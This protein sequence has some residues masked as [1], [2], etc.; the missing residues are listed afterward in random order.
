MKGLDHSDSDPYLEAELRAMLRRRAA[1]V[2]PNQPSWDDLLDRSTA[3]VVSLHT[4]RPLDPATEGRRHPRRERD[5]TSLRPAPAAAACLAVVMTAGVVI[6]RSTTPGSDGGGGSADQP[7]VDGPTAL[8]DESPLAAAGEADFSAAAAPPLL[9]DTPSRSELLARLTESGNLPEDLLWMATPPDA[10]LH[11]LRAAQL[12]LEDVDAAALGLD[13]ATPDTAPATESGLTV[14]YQQTGEISQ[15]LG[16]GNALV[17][18]VRV[19]WSLRQTD[20]ALDRGDPP[21]LT[22]GYVI[23]RN[24]TSPADADSPD[25]WT[26][27]GAKTEGLGLTNVHRSGDQLEFTVTSAQGAGADVDPEAWPVEVLV[28]DRTVFSG[29]LDTSVPRELVETVPPDAEARVTV[30]HVGATGPLSVTETTFVPQDEIAA[31]GDEFEATVEAA[32]E[33]RPTV[34]AGA[35]TAVAVLDEG[36]AEETTLVV[37]LELPTGFSNEPIPSDVGGEVPA[38]LVC[39][40]RFDDVR[41]QSG[42]ITVGWGPPPVELPAERDGPACFGWV[43][44]DDGGF[45]AARDAPYP[46]YAVG[47]GLTEDEFLMAVE[48]AVLTVGSDTWSAADGC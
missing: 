25:A 7:T 29:P 9:A 11:Y 20:G 48:S 22:N 21:V 26:V 30:R 46:I 13:P 10:G 18:T 47:E 14:W 5:W 17:D 41:D 19:W 33:V 6:G 40:F 35:D 27:V 36:C 28:N 39:R 8:V 37:T 23:L 15:Q 34:P 2:R 12:A 3:V 45:V 31:I 38:T 1:D 4:R 24:L 32:D 16:P 43:A 42:S 44:L